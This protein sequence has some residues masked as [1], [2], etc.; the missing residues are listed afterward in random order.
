M[1]K[2]FWNARAPERRSRITALAAVLL[3]SAATATHA[4]PLAANAITLNSSTTIL[5][6]SSQP[7]PIQR[8]AQDLASDM[9]KV[10]G[11]EPKIITSATQAGP[12]AGSV[13]IVLGD[14]DPGVA[15]ADHDSDSE[16]FSITSGGSNPQVIRLAGSGM[17][18]TL[19]A[20]YQFSQQ[21]LGVDPMYYWT[22]HE[23]AR[24]AAI[25]LQ[26]G[27]RRCRPDADVAG[28]CDS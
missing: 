17:R 10:F 21:Y 15:P 28:A 18:G 7:V 3:G 20:I 5:V 23:P 19:Y 22:D 11:T 1:V 12:V 6:D 24:R 14:E 8:A 16:A 13:S 9:Q 4:Q 26:R 2:S 25:H 27:A